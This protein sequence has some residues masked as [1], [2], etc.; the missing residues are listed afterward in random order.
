MAVW[1]ERVHL[2]EMHP[3]ALTSYYFLEGNLS[4][5]IKS[6]TEVFLGLQSIANKY[7]CLIQDTNTMFDGQ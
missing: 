6:H 3:L 4:D 5:V 7:H 2:V 1:K